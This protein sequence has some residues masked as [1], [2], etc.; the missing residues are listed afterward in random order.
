MQDSAVYLSTFDK[1]AHFNHSTYSGNPH[2]KKM[3]FMMR[4]VLSRPD[5]LKR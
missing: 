3:F 4:L 1:I 2:L 5:F